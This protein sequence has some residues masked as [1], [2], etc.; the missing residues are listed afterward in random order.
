MSLIVVK[1][2]KSFNALQVYF[3]PESVMLRFYYFNIRLWVI[4][5]LKN[6]DPIHSNSLI[7]LYIHSQFQFRNQNS[8]Y[9]TFNLIFSNI[10]VYHKAMI[11]QYISKEVTSRKDGKDSMPLYFHSYIEI[12]RKVLILYKYQKVN[13][14]NFS[15][16]LTSTCNFIK[17]KFLNK[18][19]IML[20]LQII[21]NFNLLLVSIIGKTILINNT[22]RNTE[23]QFKPSNFKTFPEK[24]FSC[25]LGKGRKSLV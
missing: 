19:E 16:I 14:W 20:N 10:E 18:S 1:Y 25:P 6:I 17:I 23:L 24:Y 3:I 11:I 9:I 8:S 4:F 7:S 22:Y 12:T 5:T 2:F 15:L 21:Q 13:K